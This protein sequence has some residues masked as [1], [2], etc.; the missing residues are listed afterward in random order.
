[1]QS[2]CSELCPVTHAQ[3][4]LVGHLEFPLDGLADLTLDLSLTSIILGGAL[5][6]VVAAAGDAD[7]ASDFILPLLDVFHESFTGVNFVFVSGVSQRG[8][9]ILVQETSHVKVFCVQQ[10]S[11]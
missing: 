3:P 8:V 11:F 1:M 5:R 9:T 10:M 7:C 6:V 2:S 4:L